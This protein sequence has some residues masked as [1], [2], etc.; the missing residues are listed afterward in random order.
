VQ[1]SGNQAILL[2]PGGISLEQIEALIGPVH[3][4]ATSSEHRPVAPGMLDSHYAPRTP[5]KIVDVLPLEKGQPR[6]GALSL[7]PLATVAPFDA[8]E[9]LSQSGNLVEAA[10]NFFQALHRLD[11]LQLDG[12][13]SL[14]FPN[15]GLGRALND[16]LRRA[17]HS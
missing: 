12:I 8:I 3:H 16:R 7:A 17:A 5:L 2:R 1:V 15:E 14:A 13:V 4:A 6:L 10:A 11:R 9:V